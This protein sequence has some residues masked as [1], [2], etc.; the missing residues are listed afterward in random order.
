MKDINVSIIFLC[1]NNYHI[2]ICINSALEQLN[3]NDEII[4]VDDHSDEQT[5]QTLNR[6]NK[7][8]QIKIL[9]STKVANRSYN[10]NIG[11]AV[12]KNPVLVFLDGDMVLGNEGIQEIKYAHCNREEGAFIGQKHGIH[13]DE[14]QMQLYSSIPDYIH[15]LRT[16]EGRTQLENNPLLIDERSKHFTN[17]ETEKYRWIY[18][19]TGLC[20]V[21]K[22]VFTQ[23]GRFDENFIEW[24]SEDVDL[25]YRISKISKIGFINNL[26]G[27]HI[28]HAR[29][30]LNNE[31][32]NLANIRYMQNKYKTWEFEILQGFYGY[33]NLMAFHSILGQMRLLTVSDVTPKMKDGE[34][35]IDIISQVH[36]NGRILY[37]D[38]ILKDMNAFF[39]IVIPVDDFHFKTAYISD[40]IFIYPNLLTCRILQEALRVADNVHIFPT[41]D[42]IRISWDKNR[43]LYPKAQKQHLYNEINDLLS[44]T[45]V[46]LDNDYIQVK[47]IYG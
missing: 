39:G 30:I 2:D 16:K 37:K 19:Y 20:S 18:Y 6:Y 36:P 8:A 41:T 24:G 1:H 23:A 28:P 7:Y 21:E 29:N 13:F 3:N 46:P 25:G 11:A 43:M 27:F 4:I 44:F 42:S 14:I 22:T 40:H 15:F 26:H 35:L 5:Q 38:S 33:G 45:F 10:R 47:S 17:S 31:H 12:A 9:S 32:S 34:I